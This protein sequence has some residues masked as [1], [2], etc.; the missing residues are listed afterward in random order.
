MI[1]I[2]ACL[3]C[4]EYADVA[5]S[6]QFMLRQ[7]CAK[8]LDATRQARTFGSLIVAAEKPSDPTPTMSRRELSSLKRELYHT[9]KIIQSIDA[10]K[11]QFMQ[12]A[13]QEAEQMV[14]DVEAEIG[15][16]LPE[17]RK[18]NVQLKQRLK[19]F[20][21]Q[22]GQSQMRIRDMLVDLKYEVTNAGN[23]PLWTVI[24]KKL[25]DLLKFSEDELQAFVKANYSMAEYGYNLYTKFIAPN[26]KSRPNE[27]EPGK[28]AYHIPELDV[29]GVF[30]ADTDFNTSSANE[31]YVHSNNGTFI[32]TG[33]LVRENGLSEMLRRQTFT[34]S[35][36]NVSDE[37]D[38]GGRK[39]IAVE[40]QYADDPNTVRAFIRDTA[41]DWQIV[42][43]VS[44]APHKIALELAPMESHRAVQVAEEFFNFINRILQEMEDIER[45]RTSIVLHL[46]DHIAQGGMDLP[47]TDVVDLSLSG[48]RV[49]DAPNFSMEP[50]T[51]DVFLPSHGV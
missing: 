4:G 42:D 40:G 30:S 25:G 45:E 21:Q 47:D 28:K 46:S 39:F 15:A 11:A 20:M 18:K 1:R 43:S 23:R 22:T 19:Q 50:A 8:C 27:E 34:K 7:R 48:D 6:M 33:S 14:A 5:S 24:T 38:E 16:R 10:R 26:R 17:L 29:A 31:C 2:A 44:I 37:S 41:P 32:L 13:L 9:E 3:S 35:F 36:M 49:P 12:R 51:A